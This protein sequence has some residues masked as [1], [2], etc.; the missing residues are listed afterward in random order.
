[1]KTMSEC[2]VEQ[3]DRPVTSRGYCLGHYTRLRR[4]G[5]MSTPIATRHE[6]FWDCV[7]ISGGLDACWPWKRGRSGGYGVITKRIYGERFAHRYAWTLAHGPIP[8][9]QI[10]RHACDN[11]PCCNPLH[12]SAGTHVDNMAD[13]A[14]RGRAPSGENCPLT[15][16][17]DQQ[18]R[19]IRKAVADGMLHKDVAARFGISKV[20]VS[21]L[22]TYRARRAA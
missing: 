11:P 21:T 9:G 10:V 16:L 6:P 7:D 14:S 8:E 5:D 22:V 3:C 2:S 1:M 17:T 19:D 12:L 13:K 20:Y 18:V 4:G 15:R